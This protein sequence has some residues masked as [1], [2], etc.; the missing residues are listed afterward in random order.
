MTE[1]AIPPRNAILHGD[2]ISVL[3]GFTANSVDF[4]LT[5]PPYLV[6]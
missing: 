5:D 2:C 6:R 1:L 4:V 3:G